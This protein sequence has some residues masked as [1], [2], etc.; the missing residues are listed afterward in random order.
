MGLYFDI[1]YNVILFVKGYIFEC[2]FGF[3]REPAKIQYICSISPPNFLLQIVLLYETCLGF[4]SEYCFHLEHSKL[5][6]NLISEF[7]SEFDTNWAI[8]SSLSQVSIAPN[9]ATISAKRVML[10]LISHLWG[11]GNRL[12]IFVTD[13]SPPLP[14]SARAMKSFIPP[15]YCPCTKTCGRG[16]PQSR[17]RAS[18]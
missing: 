12:L 18:P 15:S 6:Y 11:G 3:I 8:E 10:Q 9:V 13:R 1:N 7:G 16:G 2:I 5:R 14:A 17:L 4:S